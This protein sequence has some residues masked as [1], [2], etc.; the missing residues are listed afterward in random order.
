MGRVVMKKKYPELSTITKRVVSKTI[1]ITGN[2][3]SGTT[4]AGKIIGSCKNCEYFFE[5]DLLMSLLIIID[6]IPMPAWKFLFE[7]YVGEDLMAKAVM[8]RNLNLRAHDDSTFY[9]TNKKSEY[10]KRL[11]F[12]GDRLAALQQLK[13]KVPIIKIPDV[14]VF[15]KKFQKYYPTIR[16]VICTRNNH[17]IFKSIKV[18]KWYAKPTL[19]G[20][21]WPCIKYLNSEI[22]FFIK[23]N[24][25]KKWINLNEDEKINEC[26]KANIPCK[27]LNYQTF[28]YDRLI[29][30][31]KQ[32]LKFLRKL[33]ISPTQKTLENIRSFDLKR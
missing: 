21:T 19:Q 22:P 16:I 20:L 25:F 18:K 29:N 8:G 7:T 27:K 30:N 28:N 32:V 12:K 11:S 10:K 9:N 31:K 23:G 5:P 33:K 26:I 1:L 2:A 14:T 17:N 4:I 3:R 13:N 6:R 15:L 24:R